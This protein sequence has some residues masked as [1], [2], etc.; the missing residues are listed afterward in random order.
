MQAHAK[1]SICVNGTYIPFVSAPDSLQRFVRPAVFTTNDDLFELQKFGTVFMGKYRN[2]SFGLLT[3]HQ[4]SG[5]GHVPPASSFVA[6]VELDGTRRAIPP[7]A[8]FRPKI[9]DKDEISL[10][11]LTFFDYEKSNDRISHLDLTQVFWSDSENV[12]ADYSFLIGFPTKSLLI[13]IEDGDVP[14][15]SQ[16]TMRWVRQDLQ[17]TSRRL[18]DTDNRDIFVKHE[19][20]TRMS[21]EPDG[22][23][24]SPVFSLVKGSDQERHLRFDGIVTNANGDRFAVYPSSYIRDLLDH[25][26]GGRPELA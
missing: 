5:S 7:T 18:M 23:S 26:I 21:I 16:F 8:V 20:S 14:R 15:I 25:I 2:W 11:D 24:G 12:S 22:L 4:T 17:K 10:E 13:D 6:V 19:D 9:E 1:M 3:A